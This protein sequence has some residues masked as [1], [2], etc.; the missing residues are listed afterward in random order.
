[1][2]SSFNISKDVSLEVFLEGKLAVDLTTSSHYLVAVVE[3]FAAVQTICAQVFK[4][5]CNVCEV[6]LEAVVQSLCDVV[7]EQRVV[8]SGNLAHTFLLLE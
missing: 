4:A 2:R 1:M 6:H 5:I 7:S 3:R 8:W